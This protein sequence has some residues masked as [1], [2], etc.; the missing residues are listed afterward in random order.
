MRVGPMTPEPC[1]NLVPTV[2][3]G[4]HRGARQALEVVLLADPDGHVGRRRLAEQADQHDLL[5]E[6][7]EHRLQGVGKVVAEAGQVRRA[8]QDDALLARLVEGLQQGRHDGPDDR[9][10]LVAERALQRRDRRRDVGE[11]LAADRRVEPRAQLAEQV[12]GNC[13]G[14][15]DHPLLH[16]TRVGDQ[17]EHDPPRRDAEQF[18]V[19]HRGA[20]QR[21]VLDDR[22]LPRELGQQPD[23][24]VDHVVQ[25]DRRAEELL[26]RAAFGRREG[27][28]LREPVDEQPVALVGRDPPGAR[29]RLGDVALLLEHRHV[30]ADR[31]R[32]DAQVVPLHQGLGPDRL[33]GGH[34]V[35]DDGA[36]NLELPVVEH[37][38]TSFTLGVLVLEVSGT[39]SSRVRV[40]VPTRSAVVARP[41]PTLRPTTDPLLRVVGRTL[42]VPRLGLWITLTSS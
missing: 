39:R 36:E 31:R 37:L 13:R 29:V 8:R 24:A 33:L 30:V 34:E 5:L 1:D 32:G 2:S 17:D 40:Y 6:R 10:V 7:L 15:V 25:V 22:D 20:G 23:G 21:G 3:G 41:E 35:L 28:D 18:D 19:P 4:H 27:L 16:P 38:A 12:L 9:R 42:G 14:A 26:D 11:A